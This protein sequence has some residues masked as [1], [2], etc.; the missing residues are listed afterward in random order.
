MDILIVGGTPAVRGGVELFAERAR[1]A[2]V[3]IGGHRVETIHSNTAFF[4]PSSVRPVLRCV[5]QL[6]RRRR[7]GWDCVWLQYVNFPELVLL[8]VCRLLGYRV[9]VTPHLGANWSSQS[10]AVLR[11]VGNGLLSLAHGFALIS[12]VQDEELRLP[13]RVPRLQIRTFLPRGFPARACCDRSPARPLALVHAARLSAGKGTFLFLD[14]CRILR[15]RGCAFS[16]RLIGRADPA[17]LARIGEAIAEHRLGD[18]ITLLGA[19]PERQ[20][21]AA[22]SEADALVHLSSIDSFPLIVLEAVACGVFPICKNLPGARLMVERYCGRLVGGA[23]AA[24]GE[25]LLVADLEHSRV[26]QARIDYPNRR[27]RRPDLYAPLTREADA[28]L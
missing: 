17:T 23:G 6:V 25:A 24:A 11:R 7:Q 5:R 28:L 27:D 21:M 22:L 19:L 15:D 20:L 9:M 14:V 8:A 3:E 26:G 12:P 13:G 2:L 10:N 1:V 4:G 18:R 16:A